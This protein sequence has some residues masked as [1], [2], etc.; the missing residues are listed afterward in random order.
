MAVQHIL[1]ASMDEGLEQLL[2]PIWCKGQMLEMQ[3]TMDAFHWP[4]LT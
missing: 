4:K 3:R 1:A 2:D